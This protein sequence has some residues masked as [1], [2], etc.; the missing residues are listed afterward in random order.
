MLVNPGG[1]RCR[2]GAVGCW[3]TEAGEEALLRAAGPVLDGGPDVP[4]ST[5]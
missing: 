1:V 5:A 2:C 4:A 3:E